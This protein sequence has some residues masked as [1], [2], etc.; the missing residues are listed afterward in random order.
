MKWEFEAMLTGFLRPVFS[1]SST[2][3]A[4]TVETF[5]KRI[6]SRMPGSDV[7]FTLQSD[8]TILFG[9]ENDGR[10]TCRVPVVCLNRATEQSNLS[11]W[12]H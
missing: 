12:N 11:L 9:E 7:G 3:K 8:L 1:F 10:D 5:E 6:I 2:C 4:L